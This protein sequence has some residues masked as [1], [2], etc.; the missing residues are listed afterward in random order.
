MGRQNC[1]MHA[2]TIDGV[3]YGRP[4]GELGLRD[5]RTPTLATLLKPGTHFVYTYDFGDSWEHLITVEQVQTASAGPHCPYCTDGAGTCPPEDCDGTPGY[6]DLKVILADPAHEEHHAMLVWLGLRSATKFAPDRFAPDEANARLLR[7]TAP[8][9]TSRPATPPFAALGATDWSTDPATPRRDK[10]Y[11]P[12]LHP[13]VQ[14]LGVDYTA[15]R[16]TLS[17]H[18]FVMS[19]MSEVIMTTGRRCRSAISATAASMAYS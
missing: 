3:Q 6:S 1:H 10:T 5:E 15:T 12:T 17:P 9:R 4:G 7:L 11:G 19:S 2:F 13:D 16:R 14:V 8:R 18:N